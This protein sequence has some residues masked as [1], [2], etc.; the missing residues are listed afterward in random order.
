GTG[1]LRLRAAF[2]V[3]AGVLTPARHLHE[4]P[5][6]GFSRADL[7]KALLAMAPRR[8]FATCDHPT[9]GPLAVLL[10]RLR[11]NDRI[12]VTLTAA[13]TEAPASRRRAV[14]FE[15]LPFWAAALELDLCHRFGPGAPL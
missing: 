15:A 2:D 12:H 14:P 5:L 7:R 13:T 3:E 1:L 9:D 8:V 10:Q 4:T 6:L 11:G